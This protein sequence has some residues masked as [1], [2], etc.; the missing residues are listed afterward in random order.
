GIYRTA[1]EELEVSLGLKEF[2][3]AHE[4]LQSRL[5]GM[6]LMSYSNM[7]NSLLLTTGNKSEYAMGYATL[8]GDMCGG[9]APL[10]DLLKE[11]VYALSE[12]YNQQAEIIPRRIIERPP[13]AELRE[14]QTDQDSLPPYPV[15]DKL[16][17]KFIVRSEAPKNKFEK[18]IQD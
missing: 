17:E 13:T 14:N 9:L 11:Q 4:N 1:V 12:F 7:T 18:D 5:R 2:G 15:L 16:V 6:L 3:V 8:Y 10:G